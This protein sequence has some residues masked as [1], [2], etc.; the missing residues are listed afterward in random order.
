MVDTATR[1]PMTALQAKAL[2]AGLHADA[3]ARGL[4]LRV[5]P[6]GGRSWVLRYQLD[7]RRRSMHL[8]ALD[9]LGVADARIEAARQRRLLLDKADPIEARRAERA[10][11]KRG[12]VQAAWIFRKAA[13]AVHETLA[14]GWKNPKHAEQWINTLAT[15][16]Y[17]AIGDT[18]VGALDV[19]AVLAV[20]RPIWTEKP[21]TARR[22]RQRLDAVMRWAVAH[23]YAV[24]N[25]VDAAAELLPKQR[26]EVEHHAAMPYGEVPAF[27][28]QLCALDATAGRLALR[29]A[30]LTA[31]R[32][33]EVRGAA[34]AE[35]DRE[36]SVWTIPAERMK[37][38]RTHRVP[39]SPAAL[40]VLDAAAERFG[41]QPDAF[42]FP[43]Q[44]EGAALSD[45]ALVKVLRDMRADA[46][47]HGFRSSFRDWAAEQ[48]VS[49]ELAERALAHA[50]KDATEAAYHRTDQLEQRRSVMDAWGAFLT[51][52]P[53]EK[54]TRLR[55]SAA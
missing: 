35:I 27:L 18:A 4:Y 19:A 37:A 14:P 40:A 26:A 25:P 43:G 52:T 55:Q 41:L 34:W 5:L 33:G 13:V 53:Q 9:V 17:P 20:L 46:V 54:V 7:G 16:A 38:G 31:T 30:I 45:M 44:R 1:K 11:K 48:G 24:S 21:E 3:G 39:L 47:P 23:G 42:I 8:G 15:Y 29:F 28:T 2:P 12:D 22:V 10:S 36:A 49:R 6:T 50:V 51:A 32:S